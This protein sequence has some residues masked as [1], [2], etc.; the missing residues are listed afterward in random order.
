MSRDL[1]TKSALSGLFFVLIFCNMR[2]EII[3]YRR[4]YSDDF[5][6]SND[7]R[8]H[9]VGVPVAT[10]SRFCRNHWNGRCDRFLV[11]IGFESDIQNT[12][13]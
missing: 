7:R 1:A 13:T 2:I 4:D 8:L 3:G 10:S 6:S 11:G 9:L 12:F 5:N